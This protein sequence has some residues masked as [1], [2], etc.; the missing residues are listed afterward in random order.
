MAKFRLLGGTFTEGS[1]ETARD[2]SFKA[3]RDTFVESEKDLDVLFA[4][5]FE[6]VG[7]KTKRFRDKDDSL[8]NSGRVMDDAEHVRQAAAAKKKSRTARDEEENPKVGRPTGAAAKAKDGARVRG[9]DPDRDELPSE[10]ESNTS[11]DDEEFARREEEKP[12]KTLDEEEDER[13]AKDKGKKPAG[14]RPAAAEPAEDADDESDVGDEEEESGLGEDVSADFPKAEEYG[15]TVHQGEEEGF[16]V[17]RDGEPLHKRPFK[18]KRE[19]NAF[20]KRQ[21]KPDRPADEE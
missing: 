19:A 21:K 13:V 3:G 17:A 10:E 15:V 11:G 4:N 18:T 20:I 6:R 1:G 14:R 8:D 9:E 12:R 2:Y 5:K 16:V 7:E